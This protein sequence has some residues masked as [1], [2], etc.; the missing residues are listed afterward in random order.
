MKYLYGPCSK[1]YN[2]ANSPVLRDGMAYEK[3][4][5]T[6]IMCL[7]IFVTV[8][9]SMIGFSTYGFLFGNAAKVLG[10]L[11]GAGN[12]CGVSGQKDGDF[13]DYPYTYISNF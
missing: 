9:A 3:R 12:L 2:L 8:V 7:V 4:K 11:D 5:V 10:G 6:D 1:E 13:T